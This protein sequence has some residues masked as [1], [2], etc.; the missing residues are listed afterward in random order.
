M[1]TSKLALVGLTLMNAGP[2]HAQGTDASLFLKSD[3]VQVA[4]LASKS[5]DLYKTAGHHGPAV[6]NPW[7]AL[8]MYFDKSCGID[9][10][11]KQKPQLELRKALWYPTEAEQKN[12][13]G[14]DYYKVG[15][16]V[17]I[18]GIRLWDGKQ[19]VPLHPVSQRIASVGK[20][21]ATAWLEMLSEGVP[22]QKQKVDI[23][24]RVTVYADHRMAK[25]EASVV[26]GPEVQFV[27]GLNY[28]KGQ[29]VRKGDNFIAAWGLHPEDVAAEQVAV[30]AAILFNPADFTERKDDG[31][32]HL[33]ISK[34]SRQLVTRITSSSARDPEIRNLEQFV[35]FLDKAVIPQVGP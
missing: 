9:V 8:R 21:A 28:H 23:R 31:T 4:E 7:F 35:A 33:L 17:G 12:G 6:E 1:K 15:K 13:W 5:G 22:Y 27:T 34:P 10:Y 32:Q 30:G 3:G 19:A 11:S 16:T 18:G 25:V 14:A 24:V 26:N 2:C 29:D 20:D